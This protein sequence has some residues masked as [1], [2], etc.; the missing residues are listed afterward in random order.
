MDVYNRI[1]DKNLGTNQKLIEQYKQDVQLMDND[2]QTCVRRRFF[3]KNDR[4]VVDFD[5]SKNNGG[6]IAQQLCK[7]ILLRDVNGD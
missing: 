3:K 6:V 4:Q 5:F 7:G 1:T 2:L